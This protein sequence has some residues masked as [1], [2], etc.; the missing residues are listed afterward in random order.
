MEPTTFIALGLVDRDGVD[1][2]DPAFGWT[3]AEEAAAC[4]RIMARHLAGLDAT[5]FTFGTGRGLD[6][7]G[8]PEP[9]AF[10]AI[11]GLTADDART[12]ARALALEF[13]QRCVAVTRGT[14]AF[15]GGIEPRICPHCGEGLA[16]V[17]A[18]VPVG[19]RARVRLELLHAHQQG[20]GGTNA[21]EGLDTTCPECGHKTEEGT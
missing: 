17:V 15:L 3:W 4:E 20:A 21:L 18:L 10:W 7:E 19:R 8:Q 1:L 13:N 16:L 6:E 5:V 12:L 2:F 14:P 9:C 11:G